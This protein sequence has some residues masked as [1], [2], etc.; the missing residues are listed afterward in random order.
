MAIQGRTQTQVQQLCLELIEHV[1]S[2][3]IDIIV[4]CQTDLIEC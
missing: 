4:G 3:R 2:R 1:S